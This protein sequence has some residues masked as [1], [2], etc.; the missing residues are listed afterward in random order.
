MQKVELV[1]TSCD[2]RVIL[3]GSVVAVITGSMHQQA[4]AS[5]AS[6]LLCGGNSPTDIHSHGES[7]QYGSTIS[8]WD[9]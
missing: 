5:F 4:A 8:Q 1:T 2:T 6:T 9:R 3:N 7:G